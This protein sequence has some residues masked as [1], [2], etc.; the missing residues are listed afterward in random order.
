[1]ASGEDKDPVFGR[2][3][4]FWVKCG[5]CRALIYRD[6]WERNFKVCPRCGHHH[7]IGAWE[8]LRMTVDEGSFEEFDR[9]IRPANPL[10]FPGYEEKLEKGRR[11]TGL[12]DAVLTGKAK[13]G[14]HEVVIG[15]TDS[16]F[17]MGSMGS[18]V[19]EKVTRA[20]ERALEWGVP[21]IM[22]SGSGGG[23]RM[24]EGM[25]SL[26]QMAKTASAVARLNKAGIPYITVLTHPS[27]AGVL[28]SWAALGDI[29]I[30]E[31]GA[32][33][34]FTGPRVIEQN[35]GKKLPPGFQSAEFQ[36][37]HGFVDMVLPRKEIRPTLIRI[38]DIICDR[39]R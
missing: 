23:A 37:E 6:E 27:M 2:M 21:A 34:G 18:V 15:V 5:K 30:A 17:M 4:E 11:Q 12:P 16:G 38:L 32:L 24:Q 13:I 22:I 7:P 19:G 29:V 25:L 35:L 8:R 39:R 33:I 3:A 20:L 14:G 26:M 36:L 10:G 1:M 9:D 28:A 31:P